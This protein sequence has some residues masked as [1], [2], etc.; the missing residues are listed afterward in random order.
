MLRIL[1][2]LV[3]S[4]NL[5]A[6]KNI[7][8]P[9]LEK[10]TLEQDVAQL[11]AGYVALSKNIATLNS[12]VSASIGSNQNVVKE[13][14]VLIE[15]VNNLM[16]FQ[17]AQRQKFLD[18]IDEAKKIKDSKADL[19][20]SIASDK[21]A[22]E[23]NFWS[24][25]IIAVGSISVT[26]L[27]LTWSL[28]NETKKQNRALESN[29]VET[30]ILN[31]AQIDTQLEIARQQNAGFA[32]ELEAKI[33]MSNA[34]LETQLKSVS[35]QTKEAHSLKI[36]EFRQLWI[37]TFREDI[38][39]LIKS[40][41]TLKDFHSVEEGF[42]ISWDTLKRAERS[43]RAHYDEL[44]EKAE[45]KTLKL[46]I[47]AA[48]LRINNNEDYID[49]MKYVEEVKVQF[50][51][52]KN[53]YKEFNNLHAIIIEQKTKIMLMFNPNGTADEQNIVAKLDYIHQLLSIGERTF[54]PKGNKDKIDKAV[55]QLQPLVQYMLKTE[56]NRVRRVE[57]LAV[58][59][60]T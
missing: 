42:F 9:P 1:I 36:D 59:A 41:V 14:R 33:S 27:V 17:R 34:Q 20:L 54:M 44:V 8:N 18:V 47:I 21:M 30:K 37:N 22:I 43:Q 52:Y 16:K 3:L 56:W 6:E 32:K 51:Q 4:F 50:N 58:L 35:E 23:W 10:P 2:L 40:F 49:S 60:L 12:Q 29:L 45:K 7:N 46:T 25:V 57:P 48:K 15:E 24:A 19:S 13:S 38:S 11:Q 39:V 5:N 28:S 31:K 53:E 26:F 55:I